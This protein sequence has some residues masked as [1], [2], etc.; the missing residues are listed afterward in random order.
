[1]RR[2]TEY[3][4]R[5]QQLADR[6]AC[7]GA[8]CT[9]RRSPAIPYR[10]TAFFGQKLPTPPSNETA[11]PPPEKRKRRALPDTAACM[12]TWR[13]DEGNDKDPA[14]HSTG[15]GCDSA[16]CT[17]PG[18]RS[19]TQKWKR[20]EDANGPEAEWLVCRQCSLRYDRKKREAKALGRARVLETETLVVKPPPPPPPLPPP[21]P[22]PQPQSADE[23]TPG[24]C[25]AAS[26]APSEQSQTSTLTAASTRGTTQRMNDGIRQR[27]DAE[28]LDQA[29]SARADEE[30][31]KERSLEGL[32]GVV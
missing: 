20:I 11:K 15:F 13:C 4:E 29:E 5:R 9:A 17:A 26:A 8:L 31:M 22:Q 19:S 14:P 30:C 7:E 32:V 18:G 2:A 6:C 12:H 1:M 25:L 16:E 27:E 23:G 10:R 28:E 3:W 24:R 21:P